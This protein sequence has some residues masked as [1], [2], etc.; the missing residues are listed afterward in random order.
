MIAKKGKAF[1]CFAFSIS[2]LNSIPY[3]LAIE[4]SNTSMAFADN[5]MENDTNF[6]PFSAHL[7]ASFSISSAITLARGW[8]ANTTVLYFIRDA[9]FFLN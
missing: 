5:V 9:F 6:H 7:F 3:C 4:V 1:S 2:S 8:Y